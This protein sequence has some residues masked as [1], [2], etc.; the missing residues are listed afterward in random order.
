M[1]SRPPGPARSRSTIALF[2]ILGI[3]VVGSTIAIAQRS[4]EYRFF[5]PLIDVKNIIAEKAFKEPETK[6][7]QQGAIQGMLE[8][9]DDPYAVYV[10]PQFNDEF[11]KELTGEY[12]GIGAEV[13]MVDGVFTIVTPMDDSPA[14]RA[15]VMAGDKVRA[16]DGV[17]TDGLTVDE[18]INKLLG[19]ADTEVVITVER[20]G[21]EK[22]D[23]PITRAQIKSRAVRGYRRHHDAEETWDYLLDP[24]RR[25]GYIR[26]SQFTPSVADEVESALDELGASK[27]E[28]K[29]LVIDVRWDPG[30][31]L[32]QAVRIAD[33]FLDHGV[34]V[35]TKGRAY[36]ERVAKAN[37]S[38]TLPD[39]PV[40]MLI[41]GQSAS[42]S[43]VLTGALVENDRAIA[44]GERSYGKGSVQSIHPLGG[45][46]TGAS[47]KLTEQRYYLPSGRCLQ[48]TDDSAE[49][50]V[51]PTAGFFVPL[52]NDQLAE[53]LR[54]RRE[55]EIIGGEND[56]K[57]VD[58]DDAAT[59]E[60]QADPDWIAEN[61]KDPQLAEAVR[62]LRARLD[63]GDWPK[64]ED[65]EHT[66]TAVES[67]ELSQIDL[68]RERLMRELSRMDRR[69]AALRSGQADDSE[70]ASHD[71]WDDSA[72]IE[73]GSLVVRDAD[74][75][76]IA[77][78][79]IT[80]PD[81]E[82]WLLDADV[83]KE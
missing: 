54:I 69:E 7:L 57:Q 49:W 64:G 82:R 6:D 58:P 45:A 60:A 42:A 29:G 37:A 40:V 10:P 75:N 81:L 8:V 83:R 28:L 31:L 56:A 15:G 61:H 55:S 16:I 76:V 26:I 14:F 11:E 50:G 13:N 71:L 24:Q 17:S 62:A 22:L 33:M 4:G 79:R 20:A 66:V 18:C 36:P 65:S 34:I 23:I 47:L 27:G 67:H 63:T 48:R 39:F 35:S 44:V 38:G 5:D 43:E 73:G 51:D 59:T 77:T 52:D 3:A 25:I 41:N 74:G 1:H 21:G 2:A 9:L 53:L 70:A 72:K 78:L 46:A 30:G 32:D 80:G 12:V 19:Q 68:A